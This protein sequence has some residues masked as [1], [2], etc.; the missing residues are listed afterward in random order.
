M[1]K[2]EN[3]EKIYFWIVVSSLDSVTNYNLEEV[4]SKI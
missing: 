2:T 4:K 3:N 1:R